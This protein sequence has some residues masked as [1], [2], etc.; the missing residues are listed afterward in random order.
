MAW[1]M[2][3]QSHDEHIAAVRFKSQVQHAPGVARVEGTHLLLVLESIFVTPVE[4]P[5]PHSLSVVLVEEA[6]RRGVL[7]NDHQCRRTAHLDHF[8]APAAST[9]VSVSI[10]CDSTCHRQQFGAIGGGGDARLPQC[11]EFFGV[12]NAKGG[13][14][15][16]GARANLVGYAC[17]NQCC[18]DSARL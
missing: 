9:R 15:R 2:R 12:R 18:A 11:A 14:G 7:P 1:G 3:R 17:R 10:G 16:P 13:G 4:D 6:T 8:G 5:Q